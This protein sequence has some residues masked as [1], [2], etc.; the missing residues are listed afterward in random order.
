MSFDATCTQYH[1]YKY[2][3]STFL[4]I[5]E[6]SKIFERRRRDLNPRA[7]LPTYTLSRGASSAYLSTSP[8]RRKLRLHSALVYSGLVA[9]RCSSLSPRSRL[10]GGPGNCALLHPSQA[11]DSQRSVAPP[12]PHEAGFAGA[13][14]TTL[15]FVPHRLRI[16]SAPLHS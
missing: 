4:R 16:R 11:Q 9:L 3:S 14:G 12:Y 5:F 6:F 10:R 15:Y 2:T 7:G 8:R 13:P 1:F